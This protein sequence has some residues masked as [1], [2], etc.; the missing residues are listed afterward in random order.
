MNVAAIGEI[1]LHAGPANLWRSVESV[2]GTLHL[3]NQRL[4]FKPHALNIQGSPVSV[5]LGTIA[6]VELGNSLWVIP[7]QIVVRCKDGRKYK[8]VVWGRDEWVMKIRVA[9]GR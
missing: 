2:G 5:P 8:L 6:D 3:T 4:Y 7:N 1:E 9:I